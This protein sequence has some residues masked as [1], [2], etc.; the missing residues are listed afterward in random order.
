MNKTL[1]ILLMIG[2]VLVIAAGLV[3]AGFFIGR[4]AW[5][6]NAFHPGGMMGSFDH[7][8]LQSQLGYGMM[9]ERGYAQKDVQQLPY[10]HGGMG[11]A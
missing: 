3:G 11:P 1:R 4:T 10:G 9:G 5:G 7:S 8:D 6:W 2:A